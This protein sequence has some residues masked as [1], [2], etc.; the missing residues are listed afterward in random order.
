MRQSARPF[1]TR[2][3][4]V[5]RAFLPSLRRP[6]V[7]F[8]TG[9]V[10][11][12]L[13]TPVLGV[14]IASA[15][16]VSSVSVTVSPTT[17][18]SSA[19]YTIKFVATSALSAGSGTV[20]FDAHTGAVGTVFPSAASDY[21]I[22]DST[23]SSGSGTVTV[24]PTLSNS[25]ATVTFKVPKAIT[26]GDSLSVAVSAV[27][28][29]STANASASLAVSTSANTT[30]V[31]SPSYA[32]TNAPDGS[33]TETVSPTTAIAGA[34]TTL[35]FTYTAAAGG[36][37]SGAV[38]I[39]VP[40]G[41]TAPST[42]SGH[43]GYTT[44][45]VG[46]VSVASQVITVSSLSLTSGAT[47]TVT[48]GSGGGT[49]AVTVPEI[50]GAQSFSTSEKST[51][52]GTLTALSSSP[53]LTV[54][55]STDGSGTMTVS[56][57]LVT[58]SVPTTLT[59]TYTAA[60]GGLYAGAVTVT[61]PSGWSAPSTTSGH[62]GY[63]TAS[64][65]SVSVA[66]QVITVSGVTLGGGSTMT[67]AYGSGGGSNAAVPPA[68]SS[69]NTFSVQEKSTSGGTLTAIGSSPQVNVIPPDGV[70]T[71]SV[72]P[73]SAIE[74]LPT[75]LVFTYTAPA[76]GLSG[77]A[78]A[79]SVPAG[80]TAPSTTSGHAGY[81]TASTGTLTVAGQVVT[82]SGVTLSSAQTLTVT[83]GAGGG[84]AAVTPP[85]TL[86]N[87]TF[88]TSERS[89]S[90]GT[91]T[92]LSS[93]PI[94]SV[95]APPDGTGTMSVSPTSALASVPTTLT[96]T[97]TA[98]TD[99]LVGGSVVINVPSG[100]TAPST[101][102]SHA[103]YTT[104][105]AGTLSVAGQAITVSGLTLS[106][107]STVTVTYGSGGGSTGA[108]PPAS[109]GG[110][111]FA[112]EEESS[113]SGTLTSLSSSPSVTVNASSDG[114]GTETVSPAWVTAGSPTTLTFT[115]TAAAGG[116][117]GGSVAVTV[118]SGWTAPSTSSGHAGY[119]TA[120]TG[121]LAVAGQ[122]ITVSGVSLTG[123]STMTVTYGSGGGPNAV[124]PPANIGS[125]T[126]STSEKSTASG[127][128][129]ALS[130]SPQVAV[131]AS[132]DG[133][134]TFAV[135][136]GTAPA[137][138]ATT[139]SFTYTAAVG[140]TSNGSL[141]VIVP[142][143]WS[144][145]STTSGTY[146]YTTVST[147]TVSTSGQVISISG[148][149]LGSGNTLTLTYGAGGGYS[150]ALTP[151]SYGNSSFVTEEASTASGTLTALSSS[152]EVGVVTA[153]DGSGTLAVSPGAVDT[154]AST[155]L[156]FTF[157][158]ATG[159]MN[160]GAVAVT[161]PSG[162][163]APSTASGTAGYTTASTGT[164]TV[165]GQVITVSGVSLGSGSVLTLTYGAGGGSSA[166]VAPSAMGSQTFV[167]SE[168]STASGTLTG[169]SASPSV[170][171]L[172]PDGTGT[173]SVSPTS[174]TESPVPTT[175]SFTFVA[176]QSGI[177]DGAVAIAVPVGW[178]A[179]STTSGEAGYTTASAG[180]V[181]VGG[182]L[183]TVSDLTMAANGQL[184]V[185][186]G[187]GGGANAVL[188]SSATGPA[189]FVT[190]EQSSLFGVLTPLAISPVVQVTMLAARTLSIGEGSVST[191]AGSGTAA[192]TDGTGTSAAF[193]SPR[194]EAIIGN[195][196]YVLDAD[197]I[198][199][200]NMTTGAVSTVV[201]PA[202][203]GSGAYADSANPADVSFETPSSLTSDGHLPLLRRCRQHPAHRPD[204]GGDHDGVRRGLHQWL[205][206]RKRSLRRRGRQPVRHHRL[207]LLV[208]WLDQL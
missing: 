177:S 131:E 90:S 1:R 42:S 176:P 193:N 50:A 156:S 73:Q 186:Y 111:S 171:V 108:T 7:L 197:A 2:N 58:E 135:S 205:W 13:L 91:L 165:A 198:R 150:A 45:S 99:G 112:T 103:G 114:S 194:G 172:A 40:S 23:H 76:S 47:L 32:I 88:S 29:P 51:T 75:T 16:S 201:G 207:E 95:V 102:S 130:S 123:G 107:G 12:G 173:L 55:V 37:S 188:P 6:L 98:A 71:M 163:S 129:T 167:A 140:G 100:W 208:V 113:S 138:S 49:N 74:A 192:N 105:S 11:A 206:R 141:S 151:S 147:G 195:T 110:A 126:F 164:V 54:S 53:S 96:F 124:T 34:T 69:E 65:G 120:S 39:T 191:F 203:S 153:P 70:G 119:T 202:S 127:S 19:T 22:T 24:A 17:A 157:A 68:T 175:L 142:S 154:S 134:G 199:A 92:A 159:G 122:V 3:S 27:T 28:N 181:T 125:A 169:L 166:A 178:T 183:I 87:A 115:Y 31:T 117:I 84:T 152:P 82:V 158:A 26:A 128:L 20:T 97:Y 170:S 132:P 121:T 64:A 61:V 38:A 136:P 184:T 106:S 174:V 160:N 63:T 81:T 162:W 66:G 139:L 182:Q 83:F 25:N 168:Q 86:G 161:V 72:A 4:R 93:S 56:P 79:V 59:F 44:A 52:S 179:P 9:A 8:G 133:S 57:A 149:T 144:A 15:S 185:T 41:W 89:S 200:V 101:S 10:L 60:T 30:A 94:V 21:V 180:T 143:G 18:G 204:D 187:A 196:L 190:E 48:Y 109:L 35:S 118:P 43:A 80:W 67:V 14:G 137:G 189:S 77:G 5:P 46:T 78:V 104:A 62:A 33:G 145:P 36:L 85:T 155:T 146:G 148:V 116:L